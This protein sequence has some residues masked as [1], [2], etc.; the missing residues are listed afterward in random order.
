M[1]CLAVLTLLC[2]T[3]TATRA[4]QGDLKLEAQLIVGSNEDKA[5]PGQKPVAKDI[6]KKLKHLPLKWEH[7][8]V[9]AG[10]KFSLAADSTKNIPLSKSCQISVKSL[11]DSRVEL[12][13]ASDGKT[14]GRVTQSLHKG[15]TIV[16][17][18]GAESQ[19]VVLMPQ[20]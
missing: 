3:V 14:V 7:Y 10:K 19:I 18:A 11:G 1:L 12:T 2:A 4:G 8:Y 13:L 17:G 15:Q 5:G 6:E 9:E 20:D 16:A